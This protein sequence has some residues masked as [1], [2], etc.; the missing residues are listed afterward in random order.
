MEESELETEHLIE[1]D[2]NGMGKYIV[3]IPT[4]ECNGSSL[5]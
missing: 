2:V 4:K 5:N 3:Q 1:L